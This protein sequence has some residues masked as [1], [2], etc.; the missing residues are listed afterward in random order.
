MTGS[1][2]TRPTSTYMTF[3][4]GGGLTLQTPAMFT[5][6]LG[7]ATYPNASNLTVSD[8][9]VITVTVGGSINITLFLSGGGAVTLS[10]GYFG[11]TRIA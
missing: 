11:L 6:Y 9:F 3:V 2:A 8:T 7:G 10:G 5:N 4:Q 1:Y